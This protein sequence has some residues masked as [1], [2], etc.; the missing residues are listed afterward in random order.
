MAGLRETLETKGKKKISVHVNEIRTNKLNQYPMDDIEEL[1]LQFTEMKEQ[2]Q[3][4][5][6]YEDDLQDGK[7]FTLTSGERR[8]RAIKLL[9][10]QGEHDG[11]MD[12]IIVNKPQDIWEERR[13]IRAANVY[14]T[15]SQETR[16]ME[17]K[18]CEEEYQHLIEIEQKPKGLKRDWIA[19]QLGISGRTV[20]RYL[21]DPK[22]PD[23]EAAEQK[24]EDEKDTLHL[25]SC[26]QRLE[27]K[28]QTKT[29]IKG[30]RINI[31]FQDTEDLNRILEL[32]D[33]LDQGVSEC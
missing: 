23:S 4:G 1:A 18:E 26:V 13:R 11:M 29:T 2:I 9:Y 6:A 20:D 19:A 25:Q 21:K 24:K 28:F 12:L 3:P 31:Y 5:E 10:A 17:I 8:Y 16:W 33:A 32:M 14:R 30:H 27:S 22:A 15:H 7:R